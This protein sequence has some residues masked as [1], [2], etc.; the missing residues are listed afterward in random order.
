M[1]RNSIILAV[2]VLLGVIMGGVLVRWASRFLDRLRRKKRSRRGQKGEKQA[3]KF[4]RKRGYK[5]LAEKPAM[6]T[7]VEVDGELLTRKVMVDLLVEKEG[8][9]Y[10]VEVKTGSNDTNPLHDATRRQLL[11]YALVYD[12]VDGLFL[13][14]M[15]TPRLMQIRFP[16]LKR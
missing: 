5:V 10:A 8:R 6:K 13:L 1:D 7:R 15:E 14:D 11:E 3:L 9:T 16:A 4:L 12:D 2:C